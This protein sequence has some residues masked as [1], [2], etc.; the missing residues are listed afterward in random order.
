MIRVVHY[1]NHFFGQIGGKEK[2]GMAPLVVEGAVGPGM[3]IDRLLGRQGRVVA[4]VI[5]GDD[6]FAEDLEGVASRIAG[7]VAAQGPDVLVAGPAFD[8][9]RYGLACGEICKAVYEKLRIPAVTGMFRENP[10]V[11]LYR[12]HVLIIETED[13]GT[14]MAKAMPKIVGLSLRLASGE[15]PGAARDEGLLPQAFKENV[16]TDRLAADRAIDFL[17]R[18]M[19]GLPV[20]SEIVLSGFDSVKAAP[21]IADLKSATI[22]LVADGGRPSG[23]R[24]GRVEGPRT[25]K[26]GRYPID[27]LPEFG[28]T[29]PGPDGPAAARPSGSEDANRLV[30]LDVLADMQRERLFSRIYPFFFMTPGPAMSVESA[31]RIGKIIASELASARV[32]GALVAAT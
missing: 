16:V 15:G 17:L 19:R 7:M 18:K 2:A 24:S 4:T 21:P 29:G 11:N 31:S 26:Y 20:E 32:S 23:D 28:R 5:C 22:A 9:C 27:R 6:Y 13:N 30:P 1:I 14:G 12:R 10:G 3:L 8:E 25:A